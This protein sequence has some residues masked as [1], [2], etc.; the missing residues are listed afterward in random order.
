MIRNAHVHAFG[1][2]SRYPVFFARRLWKAS[3]VLVPLCLVQ[4]S[5]ISLWLSRVL[6][7]PLEYQ[8]I[9]YW[10][11]GHNWTRVF[12]MLPDLSSSFTHN[13]HSCIHIHRIDTMLIISRYEPHPFLRYPSYTK[14]HQDNRSNGLPFP[15]NNKMPPY[16]LGIYIK[17]T[18]KRHNPEEIRKHNIQLLARVERRQLESRQNPSQLS[19]CSQISAQ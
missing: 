5:Y 12:M 2:G 6:L 11:S 9:T 13:L 8:F 3:L 1:G 4:T 19:V 15:K 7:I 18:H 10:K 17:E 16:G 14:S